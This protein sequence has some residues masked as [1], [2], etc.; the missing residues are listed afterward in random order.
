VDTYK[1]FVNIP[2]A[3]GTVELTEVSAVTLAGA[4]SLLPANLTLG[5]T[6]TG[7][8][9]LG[10]LNWN[11]VLTNGTLHEGG[12]CIKWNNTL[13]LNKELFQ[14]QVPAGTKIIEFKLSYHRPRC[15]PGWKI[16][17]ND[18]EILKETSH[19]G[20]IY[21]PSPDTQ[22]YALGLVYAN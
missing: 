16:T 4:Y 20:D 9:N 18:I 2:P 8:V 12:G 3:G 17:K 21:N 11:D 14:V 13:Q 15:A 7:A 19:R 1:F 6:Y 22:T 5:Q 10:T